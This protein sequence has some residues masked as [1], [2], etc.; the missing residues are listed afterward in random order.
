MKIISIGIYV[1][2]RSTDAVWLV[3]DLPEP[4]Y[5]GHGNLQLNFKVPPGQSLSFVREHFPGVPVRMITADGV[6]SEPE[7][8][9][10]ERTNEGREATGSQ[11]DEPHGG[12]DH[13]G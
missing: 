2:T 11:P 3:T 7:N 10:E 6:E 4:C 12:G 1:H 5:P 8:P 9:A 13:T